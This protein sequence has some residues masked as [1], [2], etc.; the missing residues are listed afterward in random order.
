MRVVLMSVFYSYAVP[1]GLIFCAV[2]IFLMNWVQ[3]YSLLRLSKKP[4]YLDYKLPM[5][6][7]SFFTKFILISMASGCILFENQI[8]DNY[9]RIT[10]V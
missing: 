9:S 10:L 4:N 1:I 7:L 5:K 3:K 6:L 2:T 8:F